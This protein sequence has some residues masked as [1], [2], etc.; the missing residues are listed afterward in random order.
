MLVSNNTS[1]KLEGSFFICTNE[2]FELELKPL[3]KLLYMYLKSLPN[4]WQIHVGKVAS[5]LQSSERAIRLSIKELKEAGL[6]KYEQ[7]K[8]NGKFLNAHYTL[9]D[10]VAKRLDS[11]NYIETKEQ[12]EV[13]INA[14][15][16]S[17]SIE[18]NF[19]DKKIE[20][21]QNTQ[22]LPLDKK[23]HSGKVQSII[24]N[25]IYNK[26]QESLMEPIFKIEKGKQLIS[27]ILK[28]GK[29]AKESLEDK[30]DTTMLDEREREKL[31]EFLAYRR[32]IKKPLTL[33]SVQNLLKKLIG[34]K[35]NGSDIVSCLD[36]SI[37]NGYLGVFELKPKRG[38]LKPLQKQKD[39]KESYYTKA[40]ELL[41]N[42]KNL[43]QQEAFFM[44][45]YDISLEEARAKVEEYRS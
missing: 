41:A 37:A 44:A 32:G 39:K 22:L 31:K 26:K 27:L 13:G 24:K 25:N 1:K 28:A 12:L 23:P 16:E 38:A 5:V 14:S 19:E 10:F 30:L 34:Y 45:K 9:C 36:N 40:R 15:L 18:N 21:T 29:K 7:I 42:N 3:S 33:L 4:L 8:E 6:L 11:D 35:Q 2:I 17:F 20:T 43:S